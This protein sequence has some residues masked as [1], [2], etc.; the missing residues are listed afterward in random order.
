M[1]WNKKPLHINSEFHIRKHVFK[2]SYNFFTAVNV[3]TYTLNF[4][5]HNLAHVQ[6]TSS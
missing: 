3:H 6:H 1:Y 5:F 4:N 2:Y